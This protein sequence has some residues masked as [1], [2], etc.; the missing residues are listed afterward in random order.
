MRLIH[1]DP[2]IEGYRLGTGASPIAKEHPVL[3]EGRFSLRLFAAFSVIAL[4]FVASSVYANWRSLEIESETYALTANALP[5]IDHLT[6]AIDALRDLESATDEYADMTPAERVPAGPTFPGALEGRRRGARD[7]PAHCRSSPE[8]TSYTTRSPRRSASSTRPSP[9]LRRRRH[10][11][12]RIP[13]AAERNVRDRSNQAARLLRYL[14]RFNVEHALDSSRRISATRH[15]V[16]IMAAALNVTTLLFTFA[17]AFWIGRIFR[18]YSH[19]QRQHAQLVERRASELEVFG[20]R[21][22][23]DLDLAAFVADLLPD[24]VQGRERVRP[25]ARG[26][27]DARAPVRGP[28]AGARRQRLRLR[29]VRRRPEPRTL[30]RSIVEIVDQ[31]V[32]E[33]R[34]VDPAERPDIE[35][36]PLPDCAVR[37]S[38][39]VLAS[40]L[41]NLCATPSSSCATRHNGGS[42]SACGGRRRRPLRGEDTGP[43]IPPGLE[44]AIFLPYV[45][46]EGVTQPGLGLGP[47]D[48]ASVLRGAWR[49]RW[50]AFHERPRLGVLLHASAVDDTR[51]QLVAAG[52]RQARSG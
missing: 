48:G 28:R 3:A 11:Q 47:G 33:A 49:P 20:R 42:P 38:R 34:A 41:G 36:G 7:V 24:R 51:G 44:E 46:G 15:G 32:E 50:R 29:E 39:G 23:H 4:A 19:L 2:T 10:R 13:L 45:R 5:S 27:P 8:S 16:A 35:V 43:G 1:A 52:E 31:V 6:T 14:V 40:I 21:V 25:E 37:C 12:P 9:A 22:A 26:R 30:A 17:V 18:S